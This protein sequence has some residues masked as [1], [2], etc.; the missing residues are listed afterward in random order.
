MP[1]LTPEAVVSVSTAGFVT[2][3]GFCF[4]INPATLVVMNEIAQKFMGRWRISH[5]DMWEQKH[6]DL[7]VP[8]FIRFDGDDSEMRFIA[9]REWLDVRY[10]HANGFPQAEFIW[11]GLDERDNRCGRGSATIVQPGRIMGHF[12]S[13]MGDDSS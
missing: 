5:M 9:V 1:P 6:V 12:S 8:G 11:Q 4:S 10:S 7:V 3:I 2:V 13:H